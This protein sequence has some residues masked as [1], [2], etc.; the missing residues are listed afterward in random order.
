MSLVHWCRRRSCSRRRLNALG[1][2][3]AG[4][5]AVATGGA[6]LVESAVVGDIVAGG[7]ATVAGGI[8]T[9]AAQGDSANE[10][11]SGSEISQDAVAGLVGGGMEHL[12]GSVIHIPDDPIRPNPRH[13]AR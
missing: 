9:R 11:L 12:A 6:S 10:V 8:V 5:L 13:Q 7:T 4:A 3:V 1:G 2:A